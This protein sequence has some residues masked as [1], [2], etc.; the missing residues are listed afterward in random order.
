MSIPQPATNNEKETIFEEFRFSA[1]THSFILANSATMPDSGDSRFFTVH[2]DMINLNTGSFTNPG[3]GL[4]FPM[5]LVQYRDKALVLDCGCNQTGTKLCEHQAQ[6][7]YNI[8]ERPDLRVFFDTALRHEKINA[9]AINYGL[10]NLPDPDEYFELKWASRAVRITPRMKSLLPANDA[11]MQELAGELLF[12]NDLSVWTNAKQDTTVLLVFGQ[13]KYYRHLQVGLYEAA[14]GAG[15]KIKSPLKTLDPMELAWKT[16]EAEAVK[17]YTGI[18]GFINNHNKAPLMAEVNALR[19]IV[20]NPVQLRAFYHN[21]TLSENISPASLVP[22]QLKLLQTGL[23]LQVYLKEPF[24]EISGQLVIEDKIYPL[25]TLPV[26]YGYFILAGNALHLLGTMDLVRVISYFKKNNNIIIIHQS[27]FEVFR[28]TILA[29]LEDKIRISYAWLVAATK[30][31][32]EENGF[33][34]PPQQLVYL[35]GAGQHIMISPVMRYGEVEVS[36]LSKRQLYARDQ[37]NNAFIV[38]RDEV[39]EIRFTAVLLLQHPDFAEQLHQDAF[40]LTKKQFLEEGWFLDAFEEWEQQ[41]IKI[42]GFN[43]IDNNQ[44]SPHKGKVSVRVTSGLDWFDTDLE[45]RY[46]KQKA[47]L[48]QL[49]KALKNGRRFVQLD[50]GTLGILPGEWIKKMAAYFEA[51]EIREDSIRTPRISFSGMLQLYEKE[52]LSEEVREQIELYGNKLEGFQSIETAPS[53]AGLNAVL[54]PYQQ[55]GLNWL[56]FLDD[57]GFGGCLADDMGLGKTI[58]IIAF[59][60]LLQQKHGHQ[61]QLVTVPTSLIFNW[62]EEL[63][64]F[65]PSLK[66][67]TIHGDKRV[68][69]NHSFK[70]YDVVLTSYGLLLSN[71]HFMKTFHFNYIFL[72]ESQAIKNPGSQRYKAARLLQS[73]NKIVLTGTPIEN[74]TFDL[75]GQLSFACPGLLG[76]QQYFKDIYSQPIDKFG[77]ERRADELQ[78]KINPFILRRT[79][80]QVVTELPEKTEMIIYCEM[81]TEQ[82][83]VYDAYEKE[84]R[85]YLLHQPEEDLPRESM[86]VLQGLTKLR[87]ICDSPALLKD[88]P[89]YG[90]AS[91]KIDVLVEQ[92]ENKHLSHKI[93]VFSQFVGMLE[94][95]RKELSAKYI[96]FEYLTGQTKDRASAV[97]AFQGNADIKV[98]LISLKAG[99]T[100][101]NLTEADYVYLVDPWWN[102]A[103]ENQAIDRCYRIGQQKHVV[104]VRLICPGTIE[105]KIM[106]LQA[107]KKALVNDLV[108]TDSFVLK[109]L[110][111][112]DLLGLVAYYTKTRPSDCQT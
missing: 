101:L 42:L 18:A 105:E 64:K 74:N 50:D 55:Q 89:Y 11:A 96:P 91:A 21:P 67:L 47:S 54:R 93:L 82:R 41:D 80:K 90:N 87:Q 107:S 71:I 70:E 29:K 10:E 65:A 52:M 68:R 56:N 1:L 79:K 63:V 7:L 32:L 39:A 75:F 83:K 84:F 3:G 38:D 94:L 17:F 98:F 77:D 40:Y 37:K 46:G 72:D 102:P 31:Q 78:K 49:Q 88:Q 2:P 66:V 28:K 35:S 30:E 62:E 12:K 112:E 57:F 20:N 69:N 100:G 95:I 23:E 5:V 99:G 26:K 6:V 110:S 33:D 76:N 25:D 103:V 104:A 92:I 45:L 44:L 97:S 73:K 22:V 43:E 111:K 85:N 27:K 24:Y 106:K 48:R 14:T 86:H 51:G 15:G 59:M 36:V 9:V 19:A 109:R 108:K 61:T 81:G 34:G 16:N 4:V 13:H 58:Q 60:L 53:P 8:M